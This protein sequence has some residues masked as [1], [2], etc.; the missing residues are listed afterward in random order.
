M[1][2][3][4]PDP[5]AFQAFEHAGWQRAARGYDDAFGS[6][7]RQAIDPLLDAAQVRAGARVLDVASGPGY[8]AAAAA[9][10]G[11]QVTALDFSAAMVEMARSQNPEIEFREGDAGALSLA[12]DS[13]DAVVMN[14]GMLHLAR[15]ESAVSEALR[16][17][18]PGG[19]YAFTVW[20]KPE[21]AVGFGIIL[22]AVRKHGNPDVPL[23][24]GPPF[25]R[26]SDAG[27]CDKVLKVAGFRKVDVRKVPQVWRFSASGLLFEAFL[28]GTVRTQ[29][30]LHAQ[31]A[32]ALA[33]IRDAVGKVAGE[34]ENHGTVEI[35]MP[36]VLAAGA[37]P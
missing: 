29:A 31:S 5:V 21:E 37:K 14:F 27:E 12:D 3:L 16:V 20:A 6:L 32:P 33:A 25:F 2:A 1:A 11:A 19:R 26:F 24:P 9:Q 28:A 7:T 13:F 35:P 30:L 34:Y 4:A 23:P 10:R 22:D 15:P 17:L 36:A 18:R 8:A